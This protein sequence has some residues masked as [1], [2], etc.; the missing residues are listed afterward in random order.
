[1]PRS[2]NQLVASLIWVVFPDP[3][4]PSKVMNLFIFPPIQSTPQLEWMCMDYKTEGK[5]VV[6]F[7]LGVP[8]FLSDIR[9]GSTFLRRA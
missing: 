1:M 8:L 9:C 6:R 7:R 2:F 4:P 3:S 5:A